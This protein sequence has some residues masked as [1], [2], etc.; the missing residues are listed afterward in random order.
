MWAAT[1]DLFSYVLLPPA[2]GGMSFCQKWLGGMT[3]IAA[4]STSLLL[5]LIAMRIWRKG[6]P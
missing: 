4:L 5:L 1:A 2:D 6:A 3:L